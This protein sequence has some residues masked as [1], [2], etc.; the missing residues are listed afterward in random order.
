MGVG[1]RSPTNIF[2]QPTDR[3]LSDLDAALSQWDNQS[4]SSL[5]TKIVFGHFP[6]SFSALT[7]SGR[8]IR[9]V[10]LKHSLSAY[11]CG[12]LHTSFGRNLKRHHTSDKQ[13][14]FSKQYFQFDI[15]E[16]MPT[17]VSNGNCSAR[18]ESVAEFWEWEMGDWR[19]ARSMRILAIDSGYVSYR[20]GFQIWL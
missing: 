17:T 6:I 19:S 9:D 18:T 1:L 16:G 7:T 20:Y 12:H 5:V 2:G 14:F 3:L 15:H 13:Q 10:F 4:T 11:L 8:S